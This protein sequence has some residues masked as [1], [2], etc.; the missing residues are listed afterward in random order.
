MPCPAPRSRSALGER[1][2]DSGR[3]APLCMDSV[4]LIRRNRTF[5][6][7]ELC[8]YRELRLAESYF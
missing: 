6:R 1:H 5:N 2:G 7:P 4:H 3:A 8:V